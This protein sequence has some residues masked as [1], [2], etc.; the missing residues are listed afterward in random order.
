LRHTE[1]LSLRTAAGPGAKCR[2]AELL[3]RVDQL[4]KT[5]ELTD[6]EREAVGK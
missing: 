5:A 1:R 2:Q 4:E 3:T 6:E